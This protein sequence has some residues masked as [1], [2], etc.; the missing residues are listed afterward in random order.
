MSRPLF[1]L[2]VVDLE[3][4]AEGSDSANLLAV[5]HELQ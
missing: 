5:Q 4:L 3:A 2:S 1:Q